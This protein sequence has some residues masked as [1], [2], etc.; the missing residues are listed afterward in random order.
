MMHDI[1]KN[2]IELEEYEIIDE[3][4]EYSTNIIKL[5]S[6]G[7]VKNKIYATIPALNAISFFSTTF[8]KE[9]KVYFL[10]KF[11]CKT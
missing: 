9:K 4:Q 1:Q 3:Y 5:K 7:I 8:P 6:F 10:I 11:L 2:K